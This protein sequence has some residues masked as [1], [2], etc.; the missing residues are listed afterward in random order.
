VLARDGFCVKRTAF[1]L[2]KKSLQLSTGKAFQ[3]KVEREVY[4]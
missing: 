4:W 3:R 1:D 2:S